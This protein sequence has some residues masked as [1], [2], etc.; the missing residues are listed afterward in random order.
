M[1]PRAT[2]SLT[3]ESTDE[4]TKGAISACISMQMGE[5]MKQEQA[6]AMCHE[7]ARGKTGKELKKKSTRI[8]K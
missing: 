6:I 5:G 4:A 2:E 8:G 7:E 3:K 1:S